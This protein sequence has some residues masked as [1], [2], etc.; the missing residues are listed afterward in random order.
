M[1]WLGVLRDT[2]GAGREATDGWLVA[3]SVL[4]AVSGPSYDPCHREYR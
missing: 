1:L 3:C 4:S 2:G